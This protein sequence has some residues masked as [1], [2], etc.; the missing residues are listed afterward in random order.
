MKGTPDWAAS[1]N[2][3]PAVETPGLPDEE[4]GPVVPLPLMA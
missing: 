1:A 4:D 3:W 2:D